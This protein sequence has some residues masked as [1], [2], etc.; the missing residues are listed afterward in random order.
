MARLTTRKRNKLPSRDFAGPGRS[1][2]VDTRGRARAALSRAS[3]ARRVGRI[4]PGQ[5]QKIVRKADAKLHSRST[6]RSST[7]R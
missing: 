2:P 5:Y 7:R 1:Y 3:H 6:K 4:S